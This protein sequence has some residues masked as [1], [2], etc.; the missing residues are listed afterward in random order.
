MHGASKTAGRTPET[1]SADPLAIAQTMLLG[2]FL[3][4]IACLIVQR[5]GSFHLPGKEGIWDAVLLILSLA[6]TLTS[7]CKQLPA[8]NVLLATVI[9]GVISGGIHALGSTTGIPFGP[10]IYTQ[11]GGLRLFNALSWFVPLLWI[12]AIL[13]SRGVARLILR[14]WRKLRVYGYWLMGITILLTLIFDLGLEPFATRVRHYW[15]WSPTK[16]PVDWYGTPLSNFLGWVVAT[17]LIL[18]FATPALMKKKPAKAGTDYAPLIV[19]ISL[20]LLF[21]AGALSEHLISAAIVSAIAC[22][23]VIPFAV[24]GARW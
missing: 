8:Q 18:A 21:I 19:W 15:L 1:T 17:V 24:R 22:L 14:P 6:V 5:F 16:I 9:V 12:V 13:G 7:L 23:A 4:V 3:L 20:N 2:L 11:A 10:V